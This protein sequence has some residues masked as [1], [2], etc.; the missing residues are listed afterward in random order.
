MARSFLDDGRIEFRPRD[1]HASGPEVRRTDQRIRA[2]LRE[3]LA[4]AGIDCG[5]VAVTVA[6]GVVRLV[7]STPS[8]R[9]KQAIEQAAA[10]CAG[11]RQVENR[12]RIRRVGPGRTD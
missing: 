1:P 7:G 8:A 10:S 4:S 12:M 3:R 2:R 6:D 9:T 5:E 11:V